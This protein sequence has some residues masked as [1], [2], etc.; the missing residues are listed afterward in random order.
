MGP[1]VFKTGEAEHLGLAGSIPV[2]Y[3][4]LL[5]RAPHGDDSDE[6]GSWPRTTRVVSSPA[7]TT[8]WTCPPSAAHAAG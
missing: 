3:R 1:P 8:S 6:E 7:P 4:Q 2:R 5:H